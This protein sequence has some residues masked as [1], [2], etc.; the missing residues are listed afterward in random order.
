MQ[1]LDDE[2]LRRGRKDRGE[3]KDEGQAVEDQWVR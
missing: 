2:I 1:T 3:K